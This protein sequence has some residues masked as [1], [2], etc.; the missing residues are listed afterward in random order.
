ME[1]F[2][3]VGAEQR[4]DIN[5]VYGHLAR[6]VPAGGAVAEVVGDGEGVSGEA[7][8]EFVQAAVACYFDVGGIGRWW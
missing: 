2:V 8:A 4:D 3:G 5:V 1:R 6:T 7:G